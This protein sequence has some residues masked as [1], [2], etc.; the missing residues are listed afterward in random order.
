MHVIL[1]VQEKLVAEGFGIVLDKHELA[2]VLQRVNLQG[3]Q[4]R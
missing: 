1:N 2:C 4:V 3:A